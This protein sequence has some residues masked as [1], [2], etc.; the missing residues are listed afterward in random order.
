[1]S[2]LSFP[3]I[4]PPQAPPPPE[5]PRDGLT[6]V[7]RMELRIGLAVVFAFFVLF[8]GWA[9]FYP[10]DAGAYATGQVA[11]SGN[12]QA[13]QHRDG[14]VVT[15]LHVAE[16][17]TVKAGQVLVE[18]AGGEL[19]ATERGLAGQVLA[20]LAQRSRLIAE[21]DGL[22]AVPTPPEFADLPPEDVPLADEALALQR[23]QFGARSSGRSTERGVL[24]QRVSQLEQQ[25][26]GFQRQLTA[27]A[28]QRRLIEDELADV[29]RLAEQGYAPLSRVRALERE[30]ARLAGEDGNLRAQIARIGEQIG[31]TRL[32]MASVGTTLNED[33]ADQLKNVE[34]QLNELQPRLASVRAQIA[35]NQ[36]R[37]PADGQ[38][39]GLTIFTPGG[40]IQAGQTLMEIVPDDAS[41]VIVAEI[42]P[43]DVDNLAIGQT[44]QIMFPGLR[45][46]SPPRLEGRVTRISADVLSDPQS[47]RRWFRTEIV[48]PEAEVKK[49]G[50]AASAVRPGAPVEVVVLTR[51]RT[52]L[53]Y[54]FEPLLRGLW[55]SGSEQ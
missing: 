30:V 17:D 3:P 47:G 11:V 53:Q 7:P 26:A 45:E 28:E 40:V 35:R 51:K 16:G 6:D 20:L 37:A 23:R 5:T 19:Q 34:V 13:V 32:Q 29:R 48:V 31:E 46:G 38:V 43:T 1:M 14:G 21:R 24:S 4:T 36:I 12:R 27:N 55:R 39:V 54:L 22:G 42:A 9:A 52:A 2:D 25:Q 49:L 50:R 18:V 10:L 44:T 33:V 8:L 41:P 15:A